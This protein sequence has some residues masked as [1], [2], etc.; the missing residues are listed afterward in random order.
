MLVKFVILLQS[1]L[2][3]FF[4]IIFLILWTINLGRG[5]RL[6]RGG[7]YCAPEICGRGS[8]NVSAAAVMHKP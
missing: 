5:T 3:E 8:F 2:H 4:W 1:L 6:G 7:I